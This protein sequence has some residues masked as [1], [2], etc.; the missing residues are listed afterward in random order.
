MELSRETVMISAKRRPPQNYYLFLLESRRLSA[1]HIIGEMFRTNEL[2]VDLV[3]AS[4][5][6]SSDNM[7][8]FFCTFRRSKDV[9]FHE[10]KTFTKFFLT[11][12]ENNLFTF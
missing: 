8:V 2:F 12:L 6:L 10:K 11:C 5:V 3:A 1:E 4:Y 9:I 7:R